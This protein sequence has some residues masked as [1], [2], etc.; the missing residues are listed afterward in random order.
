VV[1]GFLLLFGLTG[2]QLVF[3]LEDDSNNPDCTP[4]DD[5]AFHDEDGDGLD[6]QCDNCPDTENPGQENTTEVTAG[7][8]AD[9]LGDVCDPRPG[10]LDR[11]V[12]FVSFSEPGAEQ[13]WE[14]FNG[15][16]DVDGGDL[17]HTGTSGGFEAVGERSPMPNPP[18][19]LRSRVTLTDSDQQGANF[20]VLVDLSPTGEQAIGCGFAR[21]LNMNTGNLEEGANLLN[22]YA[23]ADNTSSLVPV[24][25]PGQLLS[26]GS[27]LV[28]LDYAESSPTRCDVD[29]EEGGAIGS[30]TKVLTPAVTR[31]SLGFNARQLAV[32]V[33]SL[34]IV[35]PE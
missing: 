3:E 20:G 18:L 10:S 34:D 2:C 5:P 14:T 28:E 8:R 27:Y 23:P 25:A 1:R 33:H 4:A 6:D 16:W 13:R 32:R 11:R 24:Q 21:N 30:A 12:E 26:V 17:V 7:L 19:V 31:G 29:R 9:E 22:D 35:R 15:T